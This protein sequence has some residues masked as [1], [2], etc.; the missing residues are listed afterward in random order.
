MSVIGKDL[1]MC[2]QVKPASDAGFMILVHWLWD[3]VV[4]INGYTSIFHIV[5]RIA[6]HASI[7]FKLP[8]LIYDADFCD[9]PRSHSNSAVLPPS[10]A[11]ITPSVLWPSCIFSLSNVMCSCFKLRTGI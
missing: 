5:D 2:N 4:V 6:N 1:H 9:S 8:A 10:G 7:S 11:V 3:R